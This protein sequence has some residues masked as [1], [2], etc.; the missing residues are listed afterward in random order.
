MNEIICHF[1][2]R[3]INHCDAF[4]KGL[5]YPIA[6]VSKKSSTGVAQKVQAIVSSEHAERD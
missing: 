5:L 2:I 3:S 4:K 1:V 6:V